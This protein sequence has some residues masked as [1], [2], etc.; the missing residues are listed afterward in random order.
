MRRLG[1]R[2][3]CHRFKLLSGYR[4]Y[5]AAQKANLKE[6]NALIL[7]ESDTPEIEAAILSQI[8]PDPP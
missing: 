5:Y 6:I 3:A 4:Q 8:Q 7:E 2:L 1:D